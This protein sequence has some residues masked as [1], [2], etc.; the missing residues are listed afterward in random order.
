MNTRSKRALVDVQEDL[1]P[2]MKRSRATKKGRSPKAPGSSGEGQQASE[3]VGYEAGSSLKGCVGGSCPHMLALL[4]NGACD[5]ER[6][7][8]A[9]DALRRDARLGKVMSELDC[10]PQF[11][12]R[13][14]FDWLVKSIIGQQISGTSSCQGSL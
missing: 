14:A 8:V 5:E 12:R 9:L 10:R 11:R 7:T 4:P 13:C 6:T 3:N 1:Q 2:V